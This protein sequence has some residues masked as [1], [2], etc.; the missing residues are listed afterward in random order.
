MVLLLALTIGGCAARKPETIPPPPAAPPSAAKVPAT[1]VPRRPA[2]GVQ[3]TKPAPK[4]PDV[5][6]PLLLA[7]AMAEEHRDKMESDVTT[8]IQ[9]TEQLVARVHLNRLTTQQSETFSTIQSFLS[10]AKE[11]LHQKDTPRALNL[12][13]KA[14]T[15][16]HDLPSSPRQ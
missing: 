14:Q 16:A 4:A 13:E 12:A 9:D 5:E 11:A 15:L 6:E 8:M 3:E 1:K 2:P 7:P 10:K